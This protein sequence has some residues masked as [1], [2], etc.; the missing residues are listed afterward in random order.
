MLKSWFKRH[1]GRN[2]PPYATEKWLERIAEA[3]TY[4]ITVPSPEDQLLV[5]DVGPMYSTY[6]PDFS[7]TLQGEGS[8]RE[9]VEEWTALAIDL[10]QLMDSGSSSR[11]LSSCWFDENIIYITAL[12]IYYQSCLVTLTEEED[13]SIIYHAV[14]SMYISR[15]LA[16]LY[17]NMVDDAFHRGV[18][19]IAQES[20][21]RPGEPWKT[22]QDIIGLAQ[23]NPMP[24]EQLM[25]A[26]YLVQVGVPE[27]KLGDLDSTPDS[28]IGAWQ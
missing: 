7:M 18:N 25:R 12:Q 28:W 24:M 3:V 19:H 9:D 8:L 26:H 13:D 1:V 23:R 22:L 20:L 15:H 21:E 16:P 27:N 10:Q 2:L 17:S 5:M 14:K 11:E 4:G 6:P